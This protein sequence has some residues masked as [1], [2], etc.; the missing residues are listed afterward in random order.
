MALNGLRRIAPARSGRVGLEPARGLICASSE[1]AGSPGSTGS[2]NLHMG[3]GM[4]QIDQ[5]TRRRMTRTGLTALDEDKACPGYVLY[6]PSFFEGAVHLID[7][8]GEIVHRWDLP[9][10]P[11]LWGYLLENGN[12][13]YMA[14]VPHE[15]EPIS[16]QW[17]RIERGGGLMEIDPDGKVVWE[18][19]DPYQHH[20]G[21]RTPSGGAIYSTVDR[22]PD[23]VAAKVRGGVPDS[24]EH[25]MWADVVVEVDRDGD[26]IWE[27]RSQEHL[28]FGTDVLPPN[29]LRREWTHGNTVVPV[30]E[31]RVMASFRDISTVVIIDKNSGEI[32]W[33][34]GDDVLAGQHD[35]SMLPNG[36]V[37]IF[38]NGIY[39]KVGHATF[40]R[41][42]EVDP[43]GN[44]IVWEYR[45]SPAP[46]FYSQMISGARRLPNGNTLI[47]EGW[48]GRM[49]QV[50]PDGE[51]V[52]EYVNPVFV[53]D[54]DGDF[55]MWNGVFR[56]SHYL[57]DE[58]QALL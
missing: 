50:T 38:D 44:E 23:D 39:R 54:P 58:I 40:S 4:T 13:F 33:K 10:R 3:G 6:C 53:E 26:R 45:D 17:A 11:G 20:D 31:D 14:K 12:L 34:L 55:G 35:P 57:E 49:F 47:T 46:N 7:L 5:Q 52:W 9:Y 30:G 25:G 1:P 21:R 43:R 29:V 32:V 42:I 19:R 18:H 37:L 2:I 48:F 51:V 15:I 22:L 41:V 56:A 24:E 27:W 8:R 28:D 36:N 16:A